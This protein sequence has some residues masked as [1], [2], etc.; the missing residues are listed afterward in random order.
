MY[1]LGWAIPLITLGTL[2]GFLWSRRAGRLAAQKTETEFEQLMRKHRA[3]MVDFDT[4]F[5]KFYDEK[6]IPLE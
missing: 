5:T 3:G 1:L 4:L 6:R 2:G